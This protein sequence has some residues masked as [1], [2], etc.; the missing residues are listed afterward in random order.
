MNIHL[1]YRNNFKIKKHFQITNDDINSNDTSY[2]NETINTKTNTM[3]SKYNNNNNN[4]NTSSLSSSSH[5]SKHRHTLLR[6]N[7]GE[8]FA[9]NSLWCLS[10]DNKCRI[11]IQHIVSS[12]LFTTIINII[13]ILNCVVLVLETINELKQLS[14]Y[15]NY[16]FT[17]IFTI[18]CVLKIIAYGFILEQ[19]SYLRDP[20]NWLDFIVVV[21][22]LISLFP[23]INANLFALRA[24]RLLRPLK[25]ISMFPNLRMFISTLINSL[26]D[27]G[28]V[29]LMLLL[30]LVIFAVIGLTLWYERFEMRCR[31]SN[32]NDKVQ[33]DV[34]YV[35]HLCGGEIMCDNCV[36]AVNASVYENEIN[37]KA[38][39]YGLTRFDNV[40]YSL[41]T[42]FQTATNEGWGKIMAM[43]MDGYN[44]Y[45]STV[46]F[47][48]CVVVNYYLMVNLVVAV[49]LY[50]F[51]KARQQDLHI[52]P[53]TVN[54]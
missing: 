16:I 11:C 34:M 4:N 27:V 19:H 7:D 46:Y 51:T 26:L 28:V 40:L 13:I 22:G 42:V 54:Y 36:K 6:H 38:F 29:F 44:Y 23:Q 31:V 9:V 3:L 12:K 17:C 45:V 37:V 1:Q 48:V 25:T 8:M 50:N 43:L 33:L 15:S 52:G 30:L 53:L 49:L 2:P 5:I 21:T 14:D 10:S 39:N 24:F 41:L 47:V 18:E 32:D 35:E 20:W